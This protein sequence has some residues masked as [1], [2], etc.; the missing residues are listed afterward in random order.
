MLASLE[1]RVAASRDREMGFAGSVEFS[2]SLRMEPQTCRWSGPGSREVPERFPRGS[3]EV[4]ES[5]LKPAE[6]CF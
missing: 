3:I 6:R 4:P 5:Y 1:K 2:M